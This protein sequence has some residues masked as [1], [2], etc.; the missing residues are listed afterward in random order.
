VWCEAFAIGRQARAGAIA[1]KQPATQQFLKLLD[2]RCD[3]GLR[4]VQT[5]GRA[6]KTARSGNFKEGPGKINVH[7]LNTKI[8]KL[9]AII[10]HYS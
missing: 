4:Q 6:G 7:I 10:F 1:H 8:V 5:L 3:C 9:K 2:T